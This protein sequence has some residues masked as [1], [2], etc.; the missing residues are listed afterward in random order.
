MSS[1]NI[2]QW[3]EEEEEEEEEGEKEEGEEECTKYEQSMYS[4]ETVG[5][6]CYDD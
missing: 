2:A 5:E 6:V 1:R 3:E 4:G